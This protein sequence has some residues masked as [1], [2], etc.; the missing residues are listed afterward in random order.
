MINLRTSTIWMVAVP[1]LVMA[2][3]G[4][5][6]KKFVRQ[7]VNPV[8]TRV[9]QLEKS[10]ND[11]IAYLDKKEQRDISQVNERIASTDE[12]VAQVATIAQQAQGTA[13]RAMES[14]DANS[15]KISENATATSTL[16]SGV[17]N[18]LNYQ[19]VEKGDVTFA[20]NKTTL[21]AA[22]KARVGCH[23]DEVP[24]TSPRRGGTRR[25]YRQGRLPELQPGAQPPARGSCAAL[26]RAAEG[27]LALPFTLLDS[28]KK[29]RRSG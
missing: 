17:A 13:A 29:P 4:C 16:A 9:S 12:K 14:A 10:T 8:N 28:V 26:P 23:R 18:A 11:K 15:A 22:D 27:S 24:G 1:V 20:F 5:A 2:T 3:S 7:Q 19:L 21:T 25:L 6:T